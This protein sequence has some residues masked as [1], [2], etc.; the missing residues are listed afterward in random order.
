MHSSMS[1]F[2][3][4]PM[5]SFSTHPCSIQRLP[6]PRGLYC[7]R[8]GRSVSD[9][10]CLYSIIYTLLATLSQPLATG[11]NTEV[12]LH[13]TS[14]KQASMHLQEGP[15]GVLSKLIFKSNNISLLIENTF[16]SPEDLTQH[17]MFHA[18]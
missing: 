10:T 7:K 4:F 6:F 18:G 14:I 13:A 3:L 17:S 8:K 12:L 15:D 5:E 1:Q 2:I 16:S 9:P 11:E